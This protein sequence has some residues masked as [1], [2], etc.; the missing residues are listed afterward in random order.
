MSKRKSSFDSNWR[1]WI[2]NTLENRLRKEL[3]RAEKNYINKSCSHQDVMMEIEKALLE[4]QRDKHGG[5]IAKAS[6]AIGIMRSTFY[7]KMNRFNKL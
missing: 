6:K 5:S 3:R 4:Y 7:S 2:P 1:V